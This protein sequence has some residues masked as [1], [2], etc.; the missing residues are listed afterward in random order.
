MSS[1]TV[2][3]P[4]Q[5]NMLAGMMQGTEP[6]NTVVSQGDNVGDLNN[7]NKFIGSDQSIELGT[8]NGSDVNDTMFSHCND[9]YVSLDMG[10]LSG[11]KEV[12]SLLIDVG[13]IDLT[14]TG[15]QI[16]PPPEW[17]PVSGDIDAILCEKQEENLLNTTEGLCSAEDLSSLLDCGINKSLFIHSGT[18]CQGEEKNHDCGSSQH[19][20]QTTSSCQNYKHH[21][22]LSTNE[23]NAKYLHLNPPKRKCLK[24]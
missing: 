15:R 20:S 1:K 24:F 23:D 7:E 14:I 6:P 8:W 3:T 12:D 22:A 4:T 11:G 16:E 18:Q 13:D 2:S 5:G 19:L 21:C 10:E 9:D 17:V